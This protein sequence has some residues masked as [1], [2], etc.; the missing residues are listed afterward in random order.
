MALT[1]SQREIIINEVIKLYIKEFDESKKLHNESKL[2]EWQVKTYWWIFGFA[3]IGFVFGIY[4]FT[5]SLTPS[6]DI[7][8]QEQS[9]KKM[10]SE[11]SKLRILILTQKKDTLLIHQN[12]EK[13]K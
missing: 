9:I 13:G 12:S 2:S 6:K 7:I 3:V 5:S 8:R 11:L 4:N 10:E 1:R